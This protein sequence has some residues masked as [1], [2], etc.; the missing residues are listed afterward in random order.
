MAQAFDLRDYMCTN[1]P[2]TL[3]KVM[4]ENSQAQEGPR[5][6]LVAAN[7]G[8]SFHDKAGL[9]EAVQAHIIWKSWSPP[10]CFVSVFTDKEHA[11]RWA[12]RVRQ[13]DK[14][15]YILEIDTAE[16]TVDPRTMAGAILDMKVL[17]EELDIDN[18]WWKHELLFLLRI[19]GPAIISSKPL[20][21]YIVQGMNECHSDHYQRC[22]HVR[23]TF[24]RKL[25]TALYLLSLGVSVSPSL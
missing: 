9:E 4:H 2:K 1:L 24:P 7:Q 19:P 3:W 6:H 21:E 13:I 16:L 8:P 25:R 12:K 23:L 11:L 14:P 5:G 10:S 17:K 18:P 20:K 15:A 22:R